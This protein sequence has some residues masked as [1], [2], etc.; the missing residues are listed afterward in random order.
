[1]GAEPGSSAMVVAL[2]EKPAVEALS[3]TCVTESVVVLAEYTLVR[4]A[5]KAIEVATFPINLLP[6]LVSPL[7]LMLVSMLLTFGLWFRTTSVSA[8]EGL[9]VVTGLG[10]ATGR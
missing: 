2:D 9:P 4:V 8:P 7:T 3:R 10:I 5:S 1:M 6:E